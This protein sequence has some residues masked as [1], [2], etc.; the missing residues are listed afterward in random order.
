METYYV[1]SNKYT[2]KENQV[3]GKLKKIRKCFYQIL[4]FVAKKT[5]KKKKNS[6][7][8]KKLIAFQ[9]ISLK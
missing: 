3:P 5:K 4:L 2:D 6:L 7:K 9:I 1:L 8:I